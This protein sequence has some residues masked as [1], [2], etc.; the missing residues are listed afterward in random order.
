M[1]YLRGI[2][3]GTSVVVLDP[4][5]LET[6]YIFMY[7]DLVRVRGL[8]PHQ[9]MYNKNTTNLMVQKDT[10]QVGFTIPSSVWTSTVAE[11][12][13]TLTVT[14]AIRVITARIAV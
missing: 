2:V 3:V 11:P 4:P 14:I 6:I 1:W 5:A 13:V 8:H 9:F 10:F 7:I 12:I